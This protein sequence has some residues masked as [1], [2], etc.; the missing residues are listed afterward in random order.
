LPIE[1]CQCNNQQPKFPTVKLKIAWIGKT[2][3]APIQELTGEYLKR[4]SRYAEVEALA[5][6]DEAALINLA[7][8]G[9]P[10]RTKLTLVLLDAAGKQLSSE[11]LARFLSDYQDRNSA[12]L[13]FAVG[14]ADGFSG[15]AR[16]SAHML[17]SLGRM[18]LAHELA[19]VVLLEQLYRAY[20]I[21]KGHPYHHGH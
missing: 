6:K 17:L 13:L 12:P 1:N 2:K 10:S 15:Q 19:C 8:R 11:N 20:T 3:Q 7:E 4:L 9:G 5:L 16:R 21:L 14:P 18:T